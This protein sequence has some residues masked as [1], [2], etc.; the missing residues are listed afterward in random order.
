ML[1]VIAEATTTAEATAERIVAS[2]SEWVAVG[3]DV[4]HHKRPVHVDGWLAH[5][6]HPS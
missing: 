2:H 6:V 5:I 4:A 3:V 1:E